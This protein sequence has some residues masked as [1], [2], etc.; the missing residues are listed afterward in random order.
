[1]AAQ[2]R[3]LAARLDRS[4]GRDETAWVRQAYR[5]T[6]GR[7]PRAEEV[8]AAHRFLQAAE[9][10]GAQGRQ[11]RPA[12]WQ[13]GYGHWDEKARRLREFRPLPHF[14]DGAWRGGPEL[15]D[16][17]LGWVLLTAEGGHPGN[18]PERVAVRRWVAPR[19]GSVAV[20]GTLGH[21]LEEKDANCDGVRGRIV[22][23]R[24][25]V[26][27]EVTAFQSEAKTDVERVP[28]RAGDTID[29]VVDCRTNESNDSFTWPVTVTL[30]PE[31]KPD[32]EMTFS[33]VEDFKGPPEAKSPPLSAREK[34]AQVLL[35][36]NEFLYID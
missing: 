22:S 16:P 4:A 5:L 27:R 13:Y 30:T 3:G 17:R 35:L 10:L 23:S 8:A 21:K 15:P 26:A 19:D 12:I 34:Y 14:Q 24:G 9:K 28:V 36:T 11:D 25:G 32:E 18:G 7:E 20:E 1:V 31:G 29:F 33:S 6:L 2:A